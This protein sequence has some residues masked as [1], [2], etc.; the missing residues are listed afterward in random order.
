MAAKQT[1][2]AAL[3]AALALGAFFVLFRALPLDVASALGGWIAR[4]SG[5]YLKWHRVAEANLRT[6]YPTKTESE[7]QQILRDMWDNLGRNLAE[8]PWLSSKKLQSRIEFENPYLP[9][10]AIF[11]AAHLGNWEIA[12][13]M[14]YLKSVPLTL[15][16]RRVN[17]PLVEKMI[18]AIRSRHCAGLYPKGKRGAAEVLRALKTGKSLGMLVD[19][20]MNDGIEV[21]F[22]GRP[23]MTA[24]ATAE[25]A[26][27][28]KVPIVMARVVRI[29]GA[30]FRVETKLLKIST[31][32]S[33]AEI[34]LTINQQL[35]QW[36]NEFPAQ[37]LWIHRRW[38]TLY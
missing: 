22:M 6:I 20:K 16:Y 35:E 28:F 34:M 8:Y 29:S 31:E 7:I 24:Q 26:L 13:L 12:P 18:Y 19:Q 1:R 30:H 27:R 37:W 17:N 38:G 9:P 36:I 25:L 11:A 10:A 5:K 2:I 21:P 23:A 33:P 15:I 4:K 14:A 32:E 3:P